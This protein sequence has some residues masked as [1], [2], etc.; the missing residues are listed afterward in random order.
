MNENGNT[1][2]NENTE[3]GYKDLSKKNPSIED[4]K[5]KKIDSDENEDDLRQQ[6]LRQDSNQNS[7]TS[8]APQQ[9]QQ[10]DQNAATAN[11]PQSNTQQNVMNT[12][13]NVTK[14]ASEIGGLVDQVKGAGKSGNSK[15]ILI[16]LGIAMLGLVISLVKKAKEKRLMAQANGE[17]KAEK[18]SKKNS[19]NNENESNDSTK[20]LTGDDLVSGIENPKENDDETKK[21]N[22]KMSLHK[23]SE[24]STAKNNITSTLKALDQKLAALD[25]LE[26]SKEKVAGRTR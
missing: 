2:E 15:F 5:R 10:G 8:S 26:A 25:K 24:E 19:K 18:V 22:L 13:N 3:Y 12:V 21:T 7:N 20:N 14:N 1:S 11:T 6:D 9:P 4:D 16:A 17:S 23:S